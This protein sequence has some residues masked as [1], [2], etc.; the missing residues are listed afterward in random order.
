MCNAEVKYL[1]PHATSR[2]PA[3]PRRAKAAAP[4]VPGVATGRAS[5]PAQPRPRHADGDA[6]GAGGG[7]GTAPSSRDSS[8]TRSYQHRPHHHQQH[9]HHQRRHHRHRHHVMKRPRRS[10]YLSIYLCIFYFIFF[11]ISRN[12]FTFLSVCPVRLKRGICEFPS[13]FGDSTDLAS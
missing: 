10:I 12:Q 3:N 11:Y 4:A 1:P 8:L 7:G 6:A 9:H 13:I 5:L 2:S